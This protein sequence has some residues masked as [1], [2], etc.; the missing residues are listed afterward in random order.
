VNGKDA[1]AL[2]PDP[3]NHKVTGAVMPRNNAMK[4]NK[5]LPH[6]YPGLSYM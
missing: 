2:I 1:L 6:P 5:V 3:K 4:A